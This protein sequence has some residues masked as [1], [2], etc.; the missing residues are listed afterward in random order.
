[1]K[2]ALSKMYAPKNLIFVRV[3]NVYCIR[4]LAVSDLRFSGLGDLTDFPI[5]RNKFEF[6]IV[7]GDREKAS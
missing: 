4:V 1:M 3:R 6:A 5:Y 7:I 2:R